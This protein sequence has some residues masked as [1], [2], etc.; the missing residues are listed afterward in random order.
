[1]NFE[2]YQTKARQTAI[3]PNIGDNLWYPALGLCG[4]AGEV[5][6][7]VKKIY[8][9]DGGQVSTTKKEDLIKELG[10]ILWYIANIAEEINASMDNIA[11]VN[12]DKLAKRTVENKVHG[13]GDNR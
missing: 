8:R 6:E 13:D 4:E 2:E 3:Y 5:A 1:M 12:L 10:D 9:D 11:K 7:K